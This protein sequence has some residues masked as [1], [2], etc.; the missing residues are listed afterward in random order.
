MITIGDRIKHYRN[1]CNLTQMQLSEMTKIEQTVISRYETGAI[2]PPI[3][4]VKIIAKA[5]GIQMSELLLD[6]DFNK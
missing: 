4:K 5:L 1:N 2:I 6:D 3:P